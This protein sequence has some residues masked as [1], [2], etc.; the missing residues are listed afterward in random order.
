MKLI[1]YLFII[2]WLTS[3]SGHHY[4]DSAYNTTYAVDKIPGIDSFQTLNSSEKTMAQQLSKGSDSGTSSFRNERARVFLQYYIN[5]KIS[6]QDPAL[7]TGIPAL[8]L[9]NVDKDTLTVIN[10]VNFYAGIGKIKIFDNQFE[11]SYFLYTKL[12]NKFQSLIL[13]KQ[14]SFKRGQQISGY[15]T[16]TSSDF[17][18]VGN[19]DYVR[20]RIYFTCKTKKKRKNAVIDF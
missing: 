2:I 8:C 15:L 6:S 19:T 12:K 13:D 10:V 9:C 17:T 4:N 5:G 16:F 14:P 20:G 7:R 1:L 3:C 11:S 18:R